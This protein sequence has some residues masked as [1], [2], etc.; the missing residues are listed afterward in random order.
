[1]PAGGLEIKPFFSIK[2]VLDICGQSDRFAGTFMKSGTTNT[3]LTLALAV[4]VLAGVLFALQTIFRTREL[5][6]ISTQANLANSGLVREQAF[7]NDC[8]IYSK[9]H[10]AI[11]SILESV[12]SKPAK[13]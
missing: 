5:R 1:M 12:E 9:T 10:P 13:H 11:N 2:N 4:L 7:F 8:L 3:V 6:S